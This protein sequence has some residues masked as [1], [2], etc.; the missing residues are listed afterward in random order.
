MYEFIKNKIVLDIQKIRA[1]FPIL[2]RM[3]HGK[4][5][6]Y[7][8]S[9]ATTQK[10]IQVIDKESEIYKSL[11]SNIHRGV[12]Y[13]SEQCTE[14]YEESR[15]IIQKFIN[16]PAREEV[17]FT[18][19]TTSAINLVASSF[20][21]RFVNKGDEIIVSEMEHHSNIIPW[22]LLCDRKGAVIKV[23]P[24]NDNGD[25]QID[26]LDELLTER[27]RIIAVT[28]ISNVLGTVNPI[29][30]IIK[31]AHA[32]DIPV[33]IDG[34]QS[35]QHGGIDVQKTDCDFYVFSGHKVYAP[36]GIGVLYGKRKWLDEMPPWLGGGDMIDRVSFEKTTYAP[37][38]LKF[39]A[40]TSNYVGAIALGTALE[41]MAN[42]GLDAINKYEAE[43]LDYAIK[44]TGGTE[45][46]KLY[47][48]S[49]HKSSIV[50]FLLEGIHPYDTGMIL[51]KLGIAIRT[52]HLC[53]DPIMQHYGIEGMARASFA[54]YNTFEEID[55]LCEGL[56][57]VKQMFG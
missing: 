2:Q 12:H 39:E 46:V 32:R 23:L 35:I 17:I 10:P 55:K 18:A 1:D 41:Y 43:L 9:G 53:T 22:Q 44:K 25:L 27:T 42:I 24:F 19:G 33:L 8:D 26:K 48:T 5:L 52:G 21:E 3:V 45:G 56:E 51:D 50:S 4:P 7:L 49:K 38:P 37:L 6:V 36:T 34:A 14:M 15:N 29:E 30:E 13:L 54:F 16:A 20:G 31:K 57:R 11:N 28:H 40:G 47:G